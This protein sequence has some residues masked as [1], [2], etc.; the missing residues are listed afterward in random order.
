MTR[1]IPLEAPYASETAARFAAVMPAG[2]QPL[3]L[4]RTL[5]VSDRAWR[6]LMGGSLLDRGP[7]TL[8]EREILI[9]RTSALTECEYEWGVHVAWFASKVDLSTEQIG[10]TLHMSWDAPCWAASEQALIRAAD[11]LFATNAL[12]EEDF[13]HLQSFFNDEQI[14]EVVQLCGFY[15]TI[16]YLAKSLDL[17]L[18]DWAS[19]FA[20]FP[21]ASELDE[22]HAN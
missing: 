14:L 13:R 19:R 4:F 18:E 2:V 15:R 9:I 17:P 20:D 21:A 10:A 6:K 7:I 16:A 5:A 1:I 22:N 12:A 8:R 11:R 3:I